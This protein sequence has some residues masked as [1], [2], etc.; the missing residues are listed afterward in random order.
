MNVDDISDISYFDQSYLLRSLRVPIAKNHISLNFPRK[1]LS[2]LNW[3]YLSIPHLVLIVFGPY[4]ASNILKKI[5]D[6]KE[7]PALVILNKIKRAEICQ[8]F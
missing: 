1:D 5:H 4:I 2:L 8:R 7:N 6:V 3:R